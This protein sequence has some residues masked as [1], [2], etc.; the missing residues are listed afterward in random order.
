VCAGWKAVYDALV[1]RLV[2]RRQTTDEAV[3][4]L[5][6]S[7]RLRRSSTRAT[8]ANH[9]HLGCALLRLDEPLALR[10]N[11]VGQ[12]LHLPRVLD[13]VLPDPLSA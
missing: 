1:M 8:R 6:R 13:V 10:V 4:M 2:L 3:G 11:E 12:R 5:V 9:Q 7:R